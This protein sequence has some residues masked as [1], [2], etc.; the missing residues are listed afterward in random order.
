MTRFIL[1]SGRNTLHIHLNM[2]TAISN[3]SPLIAFSAIER[4]DLIQC[5]FNSIII[6]QAVDQEVNTP[7]TPLTTQTRI[8]KPIRADWIAVVPVKESPTLATLRASLGAGEAEAI[9]LADERHL[10]LLLDDLPARK[11]ALRMNLSP[12]GSLGILARCKYSGAIREVKPLV[13][14]LQNAKIFY[15]DWLIQKFLNDMGEI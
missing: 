13:Q 3:S 11:M 10:P 14:E 5:V 8:W 4:L 1:I 12:V 9:I 15:A 7:V 2:S 6:P